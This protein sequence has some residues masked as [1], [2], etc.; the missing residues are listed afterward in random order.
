M[1]HLFTSEKDVKR[2]VLV[3]IAALSV[4]MNCH[5]AVAGLVAHFPFDGDLRDASGN[6]NDGAFFGGSATYEES[7]D[8][9]PVGA[10]T[11]DGVDD[12]IRITQASDL[13]LTTNTDFA[14]TGWVKGNPG[15][16][17][18]R[19]FAE[20]SISDPIPLY[21]VGSSGS[22]APDGIDV[23][24]RDGSGTVVVDHETA[25]TSFDGTWHHFALIDAGGELSFYIDGVIQPNS[26]SYTRPALAPDVTAL[27]AVLRST[28]ESHFGGSLDDV[29][30]FNDAIGFVTNTD[31]SGPGSLREAIANA[32]IGSTITFAPALSGATLI[33]AS[34]PIQIDKDLRID[35]SVLPEGFTIS[36][37]GTGSNHRV[38]EI[39]SGGH[40]VAFE[41][42]TITGGNANEGG[43]GNL[44]G[45]IF[46][47]GGT[48]TLESTTVSDNR[49]I[50]ASGGGIFNN[51]GILILRRCA[52]HGNHAV[53]ASGGGIYNNSGS[54][55][56]E[57]TT[58]AGNHADLDGG[59]VFNF[60]GSVGAENATLSANHAVRDGGGICNIE[61][62]V[63]G[64]TL[65]FR[66]TIVAGNLASLSEDIGMIGGS[67]TE[68][69]AN[70]LNAAI[71][72]L[73]PLGKY[74][75]SML[76]MPPLPGSPV[77]DAGAPSIL[78]TDQ[79]GRSRSLDGDG[80]DGPGPDIGAVEYD[81]GM[82]QERF[83]GVDID[84]DGAAAGVE[85]AMGT[86]PAIPDGADAKAF[87]V[88]APGSLPR[89]IRFGLN[90]DAVPGTV[91]IVKRSED[92]E[93]FAEI[94]RFDG[95]TENAVSGIEVDRTANRITL[96]DLDASEAD[97]FYRL[98]VPLP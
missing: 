83:W 84:G 37:G 75:G 65:L 3:A 47:N 52:V 20:A 60:G 79:L 58:L 64:G 38:V 69:G 70:I 19:I 46:N 22:A 81:P 91:Y 39:M 67:I 11:L 14:I 44:G 66:N 13:P 61:T 95:T 96:T 90:A 43:N 73:A 16:S 1:I 4:S 34:G 78:A 48:L 77:I 8:G 45:G 72:W 97:V 82:D 10:V 93:V 57:N 15:Q 68:T 40:T 76:T 85:Q 6:G 87:A 12:H 53:N 42:L 35:A 92:L 28:G 74:S 9:N 51:G 80:A 32:K 63:G 62:A 56:L 2:R 36:G 50:D 71:P 30:L 55:T 17:A 24:V 18:Q 7:F 49:S 98:E 59:G 89:V 94:Y 5:P 41:C 33:L 23:L 29:R 25:D 27:G 31:D 86:N 26:P 88:G 54:V 21:A